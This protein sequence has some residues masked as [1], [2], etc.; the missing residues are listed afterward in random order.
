MDNCGA[1]PTQRRHRAEEVVRLKPLL[2][3]GDLVLDVVARV[4]DQMEID[5]DTPG[6]VRSAPGGSA[7]NMAVWTARLGSPV[8]F[9]GRVGDDLLGRALV[10]D[11][12]NEGVEPF[13]RMDDSNPTAVLVLFSQ[14][15]HRHMMVPSG[16]NHFL[17]L[18]DVPEEA[19][20]SAGWVHLTGYSY[21]W[22]ATSR[23][24]DRIV[25]IARDAGIPISFDPSSAGF[26]R[27]RG[28]TVPRGVEVLVPNL[29]EA[30]VLASCTDA[31]QA[32]NMLGQTVP[33]VVVKLGPQGAL[34]HDR[35]VQTLVPPAVPAG[36][37]VDTTGAGDAWAAAFVHAIRSGVG[38]VEAA[39]RANALG[40]HVVTQMGARPQLP[41]N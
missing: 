2:V 34:V 17:D 3:M 27:R 31:S 18:A 8:Q 32:A 41:Q 1:G 28:L 16:A 33:V 6:Q 7:A 12:R 19:V 37:V 22:P 39:Q 36:E 13:V 24:A 35:G 21:F 10:D 30:Q 23:A 5:T 15:T 25:A 4:A 26:I 9:V 11:L 40:A 38:A 29:Q 20:R 14:G